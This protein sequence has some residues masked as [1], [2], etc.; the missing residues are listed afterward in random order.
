MF[1]SLSGEEDRLSLVYRA[2][3]A[4]NSNTVRGSTA[5]SKQILLLWDY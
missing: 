1:F 5:V 3:C 2:V 4:G